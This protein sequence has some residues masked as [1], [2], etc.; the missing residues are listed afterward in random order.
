MSIPTLHKKNILLWP[1]ALLLCI[2]SP[3]QA[4]ESIQ[5]VEVSEEIKLYAHLKTNQSQKP[6]DKTFHDLKPVRAVYYIKGEDDPFL[7]TK[8]K[9]LL[10]CNLTFYE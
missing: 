1:L 9:Y 3:V 2:S 4:V 6:L 10:H 8:K 7:L 5:E